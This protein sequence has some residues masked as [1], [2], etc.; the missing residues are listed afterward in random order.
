MRDSFLKQVVAGIVGLVLTIGLFVLS[1]T[2][3]HITNKWMNDAL[4]TAAF[5]SFIGCIMYIFGGSFLSG[6]KSGFVM[7][8]FMILIAELPGQ[9]KGIFLAVCMVGLLTFNSVQEYIFDREKNS[10]APKNNRI[11][12]K[13]REYEE[14]EE[15]MKADEEEFLTSIAFGKKSL[16]F[17]TI[18]GTFY[19]CIK[20][21]DKYYF[22]YVGGEVRGMDVGLMKT[23]IAGEG[24]FITGKKD[25]SIDKRDILSINYR[26]SRL[27]NPEYI[28]SGSIVIAGNSTKKK[29][30]VLEVVSVECIEKFFDGIKI[31][32]KT[33]A[34]IESIR[35]LPFKDSEKEIDKNL[36]KRLKLA[37]TFLTVISSVI[38]AALVFLDLNHKVISLLCMMCFVIYYFLYIRYDNIFSLEDI[39]RDDSAFSKNKVNIAFAILVP[40]FALMCDSASVLDCI[41]SYKMFWIYSTAVFLSLL[42]VFFRFTEEY[43][44]VKSSAFCMVIAA[45]LFASSSVIQ[46]NF[47]FDKSKTILM[48]SNIYSMHVN[49]ESK[50]PDEYVLEVEISTGTMMELDVSP[51][52]YAGL[53]KDDKV[54]VAERDG[55]LK[56]PYAFVVED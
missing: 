35:N 18:S 52:F 56:I 23:N 32:K 33:R 14:F 37:F 24:D 38:S 3:I 48:L 10:T 50:G 25:F 44:K 7:C 41:T 15:M 11:A 5:A 55:F 53:K 28:N 36:F 30:Q 1:Q 19:Q 34:K 46:I 51:D 16:L 9:W 22:I 4:I 42:F 12:K 45:L 6:V 31:K 13:I 40:C 2:L 47:I 54:T 26:P 43:H 49:K 29:F 21:K 27:K 39:K 17:K 8:I 20:G